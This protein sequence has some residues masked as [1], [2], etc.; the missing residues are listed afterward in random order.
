MI[1][2]FSKASLPM[3]KGVGRV[4]SQSRGRG[5]RKFF[6]GP[7]PRPPQLPHYFIAPQS[8]MCSALLADKLE[9]HYNY[10]CV[11]IFL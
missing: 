3:E 5:H 7:P 10:V 9:V 6:W 1:T 4:Y 2:V 11:F 8:K